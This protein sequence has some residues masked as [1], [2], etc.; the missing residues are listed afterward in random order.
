MYE[1]L[2]SIC[3]NYAASGVQ[4]FLLARAIEDSAQLKLCREM[5]P[6][7]NTLVCRVTASIET[8]KQRVQARNIGILQR[9]YVA[10]TEYLGTVLD[11]AQL[12]DFVVDNEDRQLAE[13]AR[14]MLVKARWI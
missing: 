10:R 1:N 5:V 8:V 9:E 14:Q 2:R 6:V 13:V 12:E 4:R 11:H 7:A 3:K